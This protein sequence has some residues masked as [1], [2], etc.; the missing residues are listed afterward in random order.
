MFNS[1]ATMLNDSHDLLN[2]NELLNDFDYLFKQCSIG[3][4][5]STVGE[6]SFNFVEKR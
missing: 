4:T 3:E 1:I 6:M 5:F 2:K